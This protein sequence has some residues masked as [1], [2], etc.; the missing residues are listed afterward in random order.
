MNKEKTVGF[1]SVCFNNLF[2]RDF[3]HMVTYFQSAVLISLL[4]VSISLSSFSLGQCEAT[5]KLKK[6]TT[7]LS[8]CPLFLVRK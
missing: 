2:W 3:H 5:W 8:S 4:C 6:K 1:R 7:D